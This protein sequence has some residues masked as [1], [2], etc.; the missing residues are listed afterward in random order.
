MKDKGFVKVSIQIDR[1]DHTRVWLKQNLLPVKLNE[2]ST[3]E[4]LI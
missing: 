2:V 3:F 1:K 4:S